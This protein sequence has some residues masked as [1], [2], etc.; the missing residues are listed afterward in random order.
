MHLGHTS[1]TQLDLLH[2]ANSV[3]LQ[4]EETSTRISAK[5]TKVFEGVGKLKDFQQTI[6]VDPNIQSVAQAPHRVPFHIRRKVEAKL[7]ELQRLDII[8]PVNC[9]TPWV[10]SLVVVPKPMAKL[11]SA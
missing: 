11:A 8:E 7:N 4:S 9:P 1:A 5:F 6:H 2:V 10:S 3:S